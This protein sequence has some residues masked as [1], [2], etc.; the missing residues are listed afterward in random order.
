MLQS[1]CYMPFYLVFEINAL[2]F[3]F[4][5]LNMHLKVKVFIIYRQMALEYR[6]NIVE[7]YLLC[8][9]LTEVKEINEDKVN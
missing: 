1:Y 9:F 3:M 6:P 2:M 8:S 4:L 5:A 7:T